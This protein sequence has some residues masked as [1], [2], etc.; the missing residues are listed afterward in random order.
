MKEKE[1]NDLV[2]TYPNEER[3][4]V[5]SRL[6]AYLTQRL[7]KHNYFGYECLLWK[8]KQTQ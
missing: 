8:I 1:K 3:K 7:D 2:S 6:R 5:L 4:N